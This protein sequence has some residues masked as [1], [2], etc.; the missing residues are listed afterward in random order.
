[1]GKY[2]K[3]VSNSILFLI[4]NF[5]S[6]VISFILVPF[7]TYALSTTEYGTVD[8]LV[9]TVSMLAP[10]VTLGI[11]DVVTLYMVKH[12][13]DEDAI[14]SNSLI[15]ILGGNV[16]LLLILPI[17]TMLDMFNRY[18]VHFFLLILLQSLYSVLQAY[19]RGKG[20]V[21]S[22]A[23][24]GVLYTLFLVICNLLFL[25]YFKWGIVGYLFSMIIAYTAGC[26]LLLWRSEF[27]RVLRVRKIDKKVIQ[28]ILK[29]SIPL[30]PNSILWWLMNISDK[31]TLL[32]FVGV[33]ANGLYS[34]GHKLPTIVSTLYSVFQQAWQLT[35][36]EMQTKKERS[37]MY[38]KM[39]E[40]LTG[41][42]FVATS[43]IIVF[44]KPIIILFC[45]ETY[46]EAWRVVPLLT[47]S[48]VYNSLSGFIGS[49]YIL[50]K[51][52]AAALKVTTV[53]AI[54]NIFLNLLLVPMMGL[55][56]AALATCI[57]FIYM[58]WKKMSDTQE[59]TPILF[60]RKRFFVANTLILIQIIVVLI[61]DG[62]VFVYALSA[63]II[64]V[65]F[66]LYFDIIK[67]IY[68]KIYKKLIKGGNL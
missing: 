36:M 42:F 4:A 2:K 49:N 45:E 52:T 50:M 44:S 3:L 6:K 25:N 29:L 63:L 11:G 47:Y 61:F 13:Y 19:V 28:S 46:A 60:E 41:A 21:V 53:G 1:M 66:C 30:L 64:L 58:V 51:N 14:F 48:A 24:S 22:F 17:L 32:F 59:Y 55:Q 33:S 5:G 67:E 68:F 56:G 38:T 31:Y 15:L 9:S 26:V 10:L 27:W 37:E 12:E 54:I 62:Y 7:Y 65:L 16:I 57:G 8:I 34:V 39:F 20:R 18:I 23:I 43:I 35:S 40:V